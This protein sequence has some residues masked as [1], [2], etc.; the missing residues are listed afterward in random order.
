MVHIYDRTQ[1][2]C[3]WDTQPAL[4]LSISGPVAKEC[5]FFKFKSNS[6]ITVLFGLSNT[7]QPIITWRGSG[8]RRRSRYRR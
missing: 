1:E 2:I 8:S 3:S 4:M 7:A 6:I 5:S